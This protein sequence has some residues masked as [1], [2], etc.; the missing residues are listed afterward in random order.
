M[1]ATTIK[2]GGKGV[3]NIRTTERNGPVVAL[4]AV[5]DDDQLMLIT[6]AGTLL[7]TAISELRGIGRATQGVRLIRTYGDDDRVVAVAK[8]VSE[9]EEAA[10]GGDEDRAPG[11]DVP[12]PSTDPPS[13]GDTDDQPDSST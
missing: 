12:E 13:N 2:R 11:G 5:T 7:R 10:A 4:R 9:K 1:S 8:V 3:I 6:A